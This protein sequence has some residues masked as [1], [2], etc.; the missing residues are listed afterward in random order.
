[1]RQSFSRFSIVALGAVAAFVFWQASPADEN[2]AEVRPAAAGAQPVPA[3]GAAGGDVMLDSAVAALQ[4]HVSIAARVRIQV[5]LFGHQ[6]FGPGQYLQQGR[7]VSPKFRFELALQTTNGKIVLSHVSDADRL[8]LFE[9]FGGGGELSDV[10]LATLRE[11]IR[12]GEPGAAPPRQE[13]MTGGLPKLLASLRTNFHF[14]E[15]TQIQRNG[16]PVWQLKGA[17]RAE[18]LAALLGTDNND[19]RADKTS[20]NK[21]L[22]VQMPT[23]V[24]LYLDGRTLFPLRFEFYRQPNSNKSSAPKPLLAMELFEQRFDLPIDDSQFQ[25]PSDLLAK[26]VTEKFL[27]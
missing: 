16:V 9:D 10:D 2:D 4:S 1:M 8:W 19:D 20:G 18:R 12:N 27:P 7:G 11:Q 15:A 14:A 26:D 13:L 17:W 24:V 22:P 6:L 5:D 3:E 21:K 25:R 23:D